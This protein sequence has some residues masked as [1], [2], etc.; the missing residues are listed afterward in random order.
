MNRLV[1]LFGTGDTYLVCAFYKA[2]VQ[3]YGL[4]EIVCKSAHAAI[5]KMFSVPFSTDD[6]L[7][8]LAEGGQWQQLPGVTYV[9]P[10]CP[11]NYTR[12]D[13]FTFKCGDI[14]QADMYRALMDL[15]LD[16]PLSLPRLPKV[17]RTKRSALLIF[18]AK[19][20]PNTQPLF[21]RKLNNALEARGWHVDWNTGEQPLD[22]LLEQCARAEWIIGPQCGVMSILTTA[23]FPCRKSF[24]TPAIEDPSKRTPGFPVNHTFPY[25]YVSKFS[26]ED[27]DVDEFKLT[28]TNHDDVIA[29]LLAASADRNTRSVVTLSAPLSP[30][31]F[32]DRLAVLHVKMEKFSVERRPSVQR[33]Y[34][35]FN[36]MYWNAP[37]CGQMLDALIRNH[38][39]TFDLCATYVPDALAGKNDEPSHAK[40]IRLNRMRVEIKQ[41][42]D[43][44]CGSPYSDE[45]DYYAR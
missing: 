7:V 35:R 11:L 45:K 18:E 25:A 29:K 19:S 27:F 24:C 4:T 10:S 31:D 34:D 15:P 37:F 23:C 8:A 40:A 30:G 32:L 20:W 42:V 26:G 5:P 36:E 39:E 3:K 43:F 28:D 6:A 17:E 44:I 1:T 13:Q 2:Y 22:K 16:T 14:S 38:R 41:K 12:P 21:W 33:E 9:H